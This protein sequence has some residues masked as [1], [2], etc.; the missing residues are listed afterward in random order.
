MFAHKKNSVN[1]VWAR[2]IPVSQLDQSTWG[3]VAKLTSLDEVSHRMRTVYTAVG[4]VAALMAAMAYAAFA[5]PPDFSDLYQ[6]T[7]WYKDSTLM[8]IYATSLAMT[9]T[10]NLM[11][12]IY[13]VILYTQITLTPQQ[14]IPWLLSTWVFKF[15]DLAVIVFFGLGAVTGQASLVFATRIIFNDPA[16]QVSVVL[17]F[18]STLSTTI[19]F[20]ILFWQREVRLRKSVKGILTA[21][22]NVGAKMHRTTVEKGTNIVGLETGSDESESDD[23]DDTDD[24]HHS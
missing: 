18:I 8:I 22:G 21:V 17:A 20:C 24:I 11:C 6:E 10:L 4:V 1:K 19:F 3:L 9:I 14:N 12:V 5:T 2:P 7:K 13:S 16:W 15:G 23:S